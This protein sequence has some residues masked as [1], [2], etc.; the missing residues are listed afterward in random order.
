VS[1]IE[2]F[3]SYSHKDEKLR[4]ELVKHL[5][6]L[7]RQEIIT[8]WHDRKI[9][10]GSEWAENIDE[11]LNRASIILLLISADFL[12][13]DY[14]YNVEMQRAMQRHEDREAQVI[15]IIL[16]PVDWKDAPFGKLQALPTGAVPVTSSHWKN[17][18]E[19]F[20]NIAI[21]IRTTAET[22]AKKQ[23][24]SAQSSSQREF[25]NNLSTAQ[26]NL[27]GKKEK[28]GAEKSAHKVLES[29]SKNCFEEEVENLYRLLGFRVY[30][31]P[32]ICIKQNEMICELMVR[33]GPS[34]RLYVQCN[35]HERR[36][37]TPAIVRQFIASYRSI[38]EDRGITGAVLITRLAPSHIVRESITLS[39]CRILSYGELLDELLNVTTALSAY[40]AWY[41]RQDIYLC[42]LPL[43]CKTRPQHT[44]GGDVREVEVISEIHRWLLQPEK[45]FVILGDFG[46]GKTTIL[47]RLKYEYATRYRIDSTGPI[48]VYIPLRNY[49]SVGSLEKFIE[50]QLQTELD[51]RVPFS[52]FLEFLGQGKLLL[53][54]DGF[55][56]M[57]QQVDQKKRRAN[58][59]EILPLLMASPK[60]IL[61]CR[62]AYFLTDA[63]L[64]SVLES[65]MQYIQPASN[66]KIPALIQRRH[67][68]FLSAVERWNY[69]DSKIPN[70]LS[71]I[72][73]VQLCEFTERDIDRYVVKFKKRTGDD[74]TGAIRELRERIRQTYDLEDLAKRPVLL[75]I[76]V[77]TVP[78]LP[79][80]QEASPS[81]IYEA[82]TTSWMNHDYAK[83]QVRMLVPAA[84]KRGFMQTLAWQ[85]Y[86]EDILQLEHSK[87]L[88]HLSRFFQK[89]ERMINFIA[90]D[91]Q[92]CSFLE[93]DQVGIFRFSHKSFLEYFAAEYLRDKIKQGEFE[94]LYERF[95]TDEV[96]FFLGD[97]IHADG[98]LTQQ[99]QV[100][101]KHLLRKQEQSEIKDNQNNIWH[102]F[103]RSR[104]TLPN[105]S[106]RRVS[107]SDITFRGNSFSG[108]FLEPEWDNIRFEKCTLLDLKLEGVKASDVTITDGKINNTTFVNVNKSSH[109]SSGLQAILITNCQLDQAKFHGASSINVAAC[110]IKNSY[111]SLER[112]LELKESVIE[113]SDLEQSRDKV[114][115]NNLKLHSSTLNGASPFA[116]RTNKFIKVLEERW[117]KKESSRFSKW[118][119]LSFTRCLFIWWNFAGI[120][121]EKCD[122]KNCWFIACKFIDIQQLQTLDRLKGCYYSTL[123]LSNPAPNRKSEA[124]KSLP[125]YRSA[126]SLLALIEKLPVNLWRPNNPNK[127]R[128]I[129]FCRSPIDALTTKAVDPTTLSNLVMPNTVED[130]I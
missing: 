78:L 24:D 1:H 44:L 45:V 80:D 90:T 98:A 55:D 115:L 83:G 68:A 125:A 39:S 79:S 47:Q 10:P 123:C 3:I 118:N 14:C 92:A 66:R 73:S 72:R 52:R 110:T 21:G 19:A 5:S 109:V 116:E 76:I 16:R 42:Y 50:V 99:F 23:G 91:I 8:D 119:Q 54:L 67:S 104:N 22:F 97:M 4:Q 59:E 33:G 88:P 111:I 71:G 117:A 122:F 69:I 62:P 20:T 107:L 64:D 75:N 11:N 25:I 28:P 95:L 103:A 60:S 26:R 6:I 17:R 32:S 36:K 43:R 2:V 40:A 105:I 94:Y 56:E 12:N 81:V 129:S 13:S 113:H 9:L 65:I 38:P 41:E 130:L 34:I 7:K 29:S 100:Y 46:T 37:V 31:D 121:M 74:D 87:L 106:A 86:S 120:K 27:K 89:K 102:I 48:P 70:S 85:M 101:L 82:Y 93:R 30:R 84:E 57:G 61:S 124:S 35:G 49:E 58:F 108:K 53:L 96:C 51:V 128:A 114:D 15:P 18:D 63:E 112:G 127:L 126:K 77:Q